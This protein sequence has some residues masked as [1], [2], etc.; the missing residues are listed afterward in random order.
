MHIQLCTGAHAKHIYI[1][2]PIS[3]VKVLPEFTYVCD[4]LNAVLSKKTHVVFCELKY[5]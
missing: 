3:I 4:I 1:I 2:T 5:M